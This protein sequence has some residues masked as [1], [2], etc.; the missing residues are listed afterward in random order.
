MPSQH[1]PLAALGPRHRHELCRAHLLQREDDRAERRGVDQED[2]SG[3]DEHDEEAGDGR[4]DDPAEVERR[5]VERDGVLQVVAADHLDDE[6][7]AR[8]CIDGSADAEQQ[9]EQE[10]VPDLRRRR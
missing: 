6:R 2:G 10:D 1:L 8:G 4:S 9:R 3:A 7:L 5:A